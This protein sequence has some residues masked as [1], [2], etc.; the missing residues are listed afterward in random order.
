M[1]NFL[2]LTLAEFDAAFA[3]LD[4][5]DHDRLFA[6]NPEQLV[7]RL[8]ADEQLSLEELDRLRETIRRSEETQ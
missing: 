1:D 6:G 5:S 4:T 3:L 8:V 2:G 7:A